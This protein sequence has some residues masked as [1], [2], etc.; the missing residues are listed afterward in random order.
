MPVWRVKCLMSLSGQLARCGFMHVVHTSLDLLSVSRGCW[1]APVPRAFLTQVFSVA[2]PGIFIKIFCRG[3]TGIHG[4]AKQ[5]FDFKLLCK[6]NVP[7]DAQTRREKLS[8]KLVN[9]R[10]TRLALT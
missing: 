10:G 9:L 6:K 1:C 3:T 4:R 8:S 7:L 2:Y 5:D